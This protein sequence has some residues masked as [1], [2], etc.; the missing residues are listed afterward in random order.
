[1]QVLAL[2]KEAK[3]I[4]SEPN[5]RALLNG[6]LVWVAGFAFT[7]NLKAL[8]QIRGSSAD[9]LH[10]ANVHELRYLFAA[11][12]RV[13]AVGLGRG[14]AQLHLVLVWLVKEARRHRKRMLHVFDGDGIVLEIDETG[15][16]KA[17]E[18]CLGCLSTLC[19]GSGEEAGEVDKLV[20]K[21]LVRVAREGKRNGCWLTYGDEEALLANS[22]VGRH[23][24]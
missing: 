2:L 14:P 7:T 5:D 21:K 20:G 11:R 15:G 17:V 13:T 19:R 22:S 9:L 23:G 18:D 16:L 8:F 6:P 10:V 12:R 24:G 3:C 1:M 4:V